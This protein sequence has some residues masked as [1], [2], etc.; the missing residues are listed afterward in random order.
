MVTR[1]SA[2]DPL[3]VEI[4][5]SDASDTERKIIEA[6]ANAIGRQPRRRGKQLVWEPLISPERM[7]DAIAA[8]AERANP[9][10]A[11]ALRDLQR[12]RNTFDALSGVATGLLHAAFPSHKEPTPVAS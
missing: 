2:F 7:T 10:G 11:A 9:E 5:Y 4:L 3:E 6:A 12:I 8:R 1:L